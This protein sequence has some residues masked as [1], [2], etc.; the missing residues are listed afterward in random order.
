M[1][2]LKKD[3]TEE[4]IIRL[5]ATL[6]SEDYKKSS[7]G[8]SLIFKT[9]CHHG[10]SYKLYYYVK[11]KLFHCYTDCG[12]SFDVYELVRRSKGCSFYLAVDC[13]NR[14]FGLHNSKPDGFVQVDSN[15]TD[16]WEI[17]QKYSEVKKRKETVK[18]HKY[19]KTLLDYYT[20]AYPV[21]WTEEGISQKALDKFNIRFDIANNKI[22]IPHYD[23]NGDLIGIR[24]RALNEEDVAAGRKYMPCI[25]NMDNILRH[26]IQF[27]LYGYYQNKEAISRAKKV[28]IFEAEKSVLKCESFYGDN[29]FTVAVCG[30][31]ISSY[32]RRMILDLGVKEVM[33]AFDKEYHDANSEEGY[34]Y[35]NKILSMAYSF[36]PYVTTYVLWDKEN[37]LEYQDSP[38]DKGQEVLEKLMKQKYEVET[39]D[40]K[41]N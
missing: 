5:L 41:D 30:S 36:C 9:V 21:E 6:G 18:Y 28:V 27:N 15:Y 26:P 1:A 14:F 11:D 8:L 39:R 24:G 19:P 37:L 38:A 16:D 31:H 29:N 20:C 4:E 32:Q 25:I 3:F 7:D 13:I 35:A 34:E 10:D 40:E 22:V 12:D 33:L 23:M 17:I 2:E